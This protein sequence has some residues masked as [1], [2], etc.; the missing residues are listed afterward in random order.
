MKT[1]IMKKIITIIAFIS[2]NLSS[3]FA[4]ALVFK[5]DPMVLIP[6]QEYMELAPGAVV[7]G[8][9][10]LFNVVTVGAEGGYFYEKDFQSG[11]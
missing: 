1:N 11:N 9:V 10:D 7:S 5:L 8:G 3:L 4:L 2:L 6:R